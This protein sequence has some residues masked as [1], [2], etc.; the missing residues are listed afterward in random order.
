[1]KTKRYARIILIVGIIVLAV[2]L[3]VFQMWGR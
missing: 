1:M 2:M 3:V